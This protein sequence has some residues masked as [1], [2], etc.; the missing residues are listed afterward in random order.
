MS[1]C[2]QIFGPTHFQWTKRFTSQVHLQ[3]TKPTQRT[4]CAVLMHEYFSKTCKLSWQP[5]RPGGPE[6]W[7]PP[8]RP[9]P[10]Q[11]VMAMGCPWIYWCL[12]GAGLLYRASK[13]TLCLLSFNGYL[14][15]C[16]CDVRHFFH[17]THVLS[18]IFAFSCVSIL[19]WVISFTVYFPPNRI[20]P[21]SH[22]PNLLGRFMNLMF[23]V[24]IY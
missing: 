13:H 9:P 15:L 17:S 8:C 22:P 14:S 24:W 16:E 19:P 3:N 23:M 4:H 1:T 6:P 2:R 21:V 5:K 7:T 10:L 20:I 11:S 12:A 18:L